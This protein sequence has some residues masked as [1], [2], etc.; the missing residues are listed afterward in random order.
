MLKN[1]SKK[2]VSPAYIRNREDEQHQGTAHIVIPQK[3]FLLDDLN[4]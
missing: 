3:C 4:L 1:L 2:T